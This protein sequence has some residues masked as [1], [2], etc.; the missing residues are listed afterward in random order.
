VE[1]EAVSGQGSAL[2]PAF[3]FGA[4]Y[5][6]TGAGVNYS[7]RLSALTDLT[8][9]ATYTR[10]TPNTTDVA[11]ANLRTNNFNTFLALNTRFTPK[12]SGSIGVSYFVFETPGSNTGSPS[13]L[14]VYASISHTF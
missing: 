1:S 7:H 11:L 12:T 9:S 13:T 10:T 5:I 4:N 6:E 3:Q 2:P 8:A 14:S